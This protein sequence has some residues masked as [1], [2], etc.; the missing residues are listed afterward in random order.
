MAKNV[1]KKFTRDVMLDDV[2]GGP[3]VLQD[4]IIGHSRWSVTH[5]LTFVEDQRIWQTVYSVGATESQDESPWE[6]QDEV[7]CTEVHAVEQKQIVY[8]PVEIS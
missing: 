2:L 4:I 6:Y 8:V 1:T 3:A 7:E 5:R